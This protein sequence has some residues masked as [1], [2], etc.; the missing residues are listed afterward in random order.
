MDVLE[1][2]DYEKDEWVVIEN[3]GYFMLLVFL[4]YKKDW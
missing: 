4:W 3:I 1:V 2:Y